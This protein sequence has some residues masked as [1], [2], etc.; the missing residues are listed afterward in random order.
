MNS[1]FDLLIIGSGIAGLAAAI[2]AK[3][4]G[5]DCAII[6]LENKASAERLL[7]LHP[8][9]EV[10]LGELGISSFLQNSKVLRPEGMISSID[11]IEEFRPYGEDETGFWKGYLLS[12]NTLVKALRQRVSQLGVNTY[13]AK[14][15]TIL[16]SQDNSIAGVNIGLDDLKAK[17]I[18]DASGPRNIIARSLKLKHLIGSPKLIA[19]TEW[20]KAEGKSQVPVFHAVKE[21]WS[22]SANIP[23]VGKSTVRLS[24]LPAKKNI[25]KFDGIK[26]DVTW[27]FLPESAGKGYVVIGDAALQLDP[28]TG[29]GVIRAFMMAAKA[30]KLFNDPNLSS[31]YKS[32]LYSLAIHDGKE[33]A[34]LYSAYPFEVAWAAKHSWA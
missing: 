15:V 18:I 7:A 26:N 6:S 29:N 13:K 5:I 19:L 1:I 25:G 10:I 28:A 12:Y 32:W 33:L 20:Q 3:K 34:K 8:G 17:L 2:F 14:R 24:L 30:V 23:N 9:V 16:K 21:G 22:W 31:A 4:N 11:N 27:K